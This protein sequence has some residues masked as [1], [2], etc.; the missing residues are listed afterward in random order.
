MKHTLMI[1]II[2]F[3]IIILFLDFKYNCSD[4]KIISKNLI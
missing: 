4:I 2:I 3:I 1:L